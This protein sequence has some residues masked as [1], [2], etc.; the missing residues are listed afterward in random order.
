MVSCIP[1]AVP[2]SH[3]RTDKDEDRK[4]AGGLGP[5]PA[6]LNQGDAHADRPDRKPQRYGD[7]KHHQDED[8][9]R[10]CGQPEC[11]RSMQTCRQQQARMQHSTT[12]HL[13]GLQ[14][15]PLLPRGCTRIVCSND[16]IA[17]EGS[18]IETCADVIVEG[19]HVRSD[20]SDIDAGLIGIMAPDQ[21]ERVTGQKGWNEGRCRCVQCGDCSSPASTHAAGAIAAAY[22]RRRGIR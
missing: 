19:H 14:S 8:G 5:T 4:R 3:E 10:R 7:R 16:H 22:D 20:I 13:R 18:Q 1:G 11:Q 17:E 6:M 9:G 12:T 15:G 2:Q 21:V